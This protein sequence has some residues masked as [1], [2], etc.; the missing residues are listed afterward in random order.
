MADRPVVVTSEEQPAEQAMR[1]NDC[2]LPT[3]PFLHV[4]VECLQEHGHTIKHICPT[5][6]NP[7]FD[8]ILIDEYNILAVAS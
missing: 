2:I 6:S 7:N 5:A 4:S 8:R 3:R 1:Y